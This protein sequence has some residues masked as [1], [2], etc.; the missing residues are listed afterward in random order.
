MLDPGVQL[1]C[2]WKSKPVLVVNIL[3][4][5][6]AIRPCVTS[7]QSPL[8]ISAITRRLGHDGPGSRSLLLTLAPM[9]PL[10]TTT[11]PQNSSQQSFTYAKSKTMHS[12]FQTQEKSGYFNMSK[13]VCIMIFVALSLDLVSCFLWLVWVWAAK[14]CHVPVMCR[15][16]GF[17]DKNTLR[18][19]S[20]HYNQKH[21]Q[22]HTPHD[23][24]AYSLILTIG[25]MKETGN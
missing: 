7:D 12:F 11:T 17:C 20:W 2:L 1:F 22:C 23:Q 19:I 25:K 15:G 9:S 5:E 3:D 13:F 16:P 21:D 14:L 24:L 10:V 6:E 18:Y 4:A 8:A